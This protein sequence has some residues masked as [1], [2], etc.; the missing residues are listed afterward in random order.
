MISV[1]ASGGF[2]KTTN[3]LNKLKRAAFLSDLDRFGREGVA[4]LASAT[5]TSSGHTASSWSYEIR[6]GRGRYEIVWY[7]SHVEDGVNIAVILQ[8]GHGTR[9][10]GYVQ[11]REYI[12]TA[13]RPVFDRMAA[14]AWKGVVSL[15]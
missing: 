2:E 10:G 4:A 1:E 6:K 7:N 15:A 5:P 8:Y 11:G 3:Y 14:Q 9:N 12:N 13:L